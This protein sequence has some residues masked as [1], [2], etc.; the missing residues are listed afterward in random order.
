VKVF[1]TDAADPVKL[2]EAGLPMVRVIGRTP[3]T[4]FVAEDEIAS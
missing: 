2:V 4:T 1:V 3:K